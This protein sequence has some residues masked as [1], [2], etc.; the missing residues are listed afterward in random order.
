MMVTSLFLTIGANKN[1]K[2]LVITETDFFSHHVIA[3]NSWKP[4]YCRSHH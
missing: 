2:R 1:S 4:T 3:Q